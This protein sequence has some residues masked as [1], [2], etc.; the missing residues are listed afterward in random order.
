MCV[1]SLSLAQGGGAMS[2]VASAK[3][4]DSGG[5][6]LRQIMTTGGGTMYVIA[7]LSLLTVFFIVFFGMVVRNSQVAPTALRREIV[8]K[9]RN[10]DMEEAARACD[11]RPCAL[12]S[13]ALAG[14]E[15]MKNTKEP[16]PVM[17]KD[18]IEGE[19][20]RQSEAIQGQTQYLLDIAVIAPMLGLL[21]TVV[22]MLQA[23]NSVALEIASAKPMQLFNGVSQALVATAF[24][25]IVGIPAMGF[26]GF[27]RRRAANVVSYLEVAAIE[28]M[29]AFN[30]GKSKK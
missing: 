9:I 17:L 18:V 24:G 19:G 7:A 23:F 6:S 15:Y 2:P 13:I 10:G 21:G 1:S 11:Y 22:G 28:V 8:E 25:L 3:A 5:R 20:S 4:D 16:D 14:I 27:F 29:A 30:I 12:S 26:Y